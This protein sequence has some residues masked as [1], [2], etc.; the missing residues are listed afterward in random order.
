MWKNNC[1][2]GMYWWKKKMTLKMSME[3]YLWDWRSQK[4]LCEKKILKMSWEWERS[5]Q[6]KNA[7]M[8]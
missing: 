2:R 1:E 5:S 8:G 3:Y 6:N 7:F 4:V